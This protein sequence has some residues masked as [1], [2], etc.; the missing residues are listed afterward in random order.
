MITID[1]ARCNLCGICTEI[2]HEHCIY[3]HDA[4]VS[5]D[6]KY[7]STCTQ[8][9]AV[10]PQQALSWDHIEPAKFNKELYPEPSQM[11]EL[12]KERRTVR[13]FKDVKI[14]RKL[15]EEI[16]SYAIYAPTH[17][18]NMRAIIIDDEK[19][20][21]RIDQVIYRHSLWIYRTFYK[22]RFLSHLIRLLTP[23]RVHEYL[24]AKP[25]LESAS[26]RKRSFKSVPAAIVMIV[27]DKRI[28]LSLESAQYALY[29]ID[30]YAQVKGLGCRNLVGNQMFL[31]KSKPLRKLIKLTKY[32]KIFGTMAIGYPAVRFSNKV[33]GKKIHIQ[34][35]N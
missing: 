16:V 17:S 2:C 21:S 9:I 14:D 23:G 20:I 4:S 31:N 6:H 13:D 22:H 25:K 19:M 5:I 3:L 28:P 30:L 11:E 12:F 24:K 33:N 18:Y 29:N 27:A 1:Q 34:W 7:C 35:N 10:C 32:E 26:D 15:L 8:C